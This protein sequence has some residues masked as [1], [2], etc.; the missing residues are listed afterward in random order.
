M[1]MTQPQISGGAAA[2][3]SASGCRRQTFHDFFESW[4]VEQNQYLQELLHASKNHPE[5]QDLLRPLIQR[6]LNHYRH[7]YR[8]KS[9]LAKDDILAMFNPSWR[10]SFEDA[11]LWIGGWRPTMAFHLLYSKSGLQL[12]ANLTHLLQVQ[13][14]LI[15]TRDLADLSL[16]QL[17]QIDK[18][19][20][21]TVKEE[22][23]ITEKLAKHQE[24]LADP[25]MVQLAH[26]ATDDDEQQPIPM[27][28]TQLEAALA[29]KEEGLVEVLKKADELRLKTLTNVIQ[30]LTPIQ[31]VHFLISAAELHLRVHEWGKRRDT[32]RNNNNNNNDI[33]HPPPPPPPPPPFD[34]SGGGNGDGDHS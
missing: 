17:E 20:T 29:T 25:A 18:L 26:A 24:R 7:Y 32:R 10:S 21:A 5:D 33:N 8:S 30:V 34:G 19:Q 3:A 27:D 28:E 12:Q 13:D 9:T 15:H 31:S 4:I 2:T 14:L 6:V 1:I 22:K 11:F 23:A 16:R